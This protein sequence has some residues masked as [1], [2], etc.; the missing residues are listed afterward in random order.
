MTAVRLDGF[1]IHIGLHEDDLASLEGRARTRGMTVIHLDLED[2]ADRDSL[3][4]YLGREFLFPSE[5][6]GLDA[7]IDSMSD[8]EWFDNSNGYLVTVRGLD[9]ASLIAEPFLSILPNV[10]DRWRSQAVHFIVVLTSDGG[11]LRGALDAANR[12]MARSGALPWAQPGTGAVDIVIHRDH[13][14]G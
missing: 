9:D 10:V 12:D 11:R 14:L 7:A 5:A 8:L 1:S 2:I 6:R 4:S 3:L 13:R